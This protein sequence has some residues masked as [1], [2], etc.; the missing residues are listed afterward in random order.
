MAER[1]TERVTG[2]AA[3]GPSAERAQS[4][5]SAGVARCEREHARL[6]RATEAL[7]APF[8]LIDLDA[9][10]ANADDLERRAAGLPIRL[11]S[12]S[13]RCRALQQRVLERAGF[14]GTLA[15]TLPEA[16]WLASH[17]VDDIIVAYP[18]ADARALRE[19][20]ERSPAAAERITVMVDS[21]EQLDWIDRV[22][23]GAGSGAGGGAGSG[24][25]G[26]GELRVCIDVDAGWRVLGG[27]VRI[28][29]RDTTRWYTVVGVTNDVHH[30]ALVGTVKPQFYATL[31]QFASAPGST[32]RSMS[33][34][35]RTDGDPT[36]RINLAAGRREREPRRSR[37]L[38][39][40]KA[41]SVACLA[42]G[43]A[44]RS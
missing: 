14:Q 7:D 37:G 27:R 11:A 17:G 2:R 41:K 24:A 23:A 18:T 21:V 20:A 42:S 5:E 4:A 6:E 30:N 22:L 15:F 35:V 8:A 38:L 28:N 25:G 32:R 40:N 16:L 39:Q 44:E 34:V 26:G 36:A 43:N 29:S 19:L 33:L 10:R 9:L 1:L 13:L 3:R 12:K 31:A